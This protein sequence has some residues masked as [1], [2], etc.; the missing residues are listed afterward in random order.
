MSQ[1]IKP[2]ETLLTDLASPNYR[3]RW[4]AVQRLGEARDPRALE[5]LTVA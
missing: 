1:S 3:V 4:R 5:R 2:L